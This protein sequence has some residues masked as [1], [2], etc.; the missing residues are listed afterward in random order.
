MGVLDEQTAAPV[1]IKA[2]GA[3]TRSSR[4]FRLGLLADAGGAHEDKCPGWLATTALMCLA[5]RL[6]RVF[7]V[8]PVVDG[9]NQ[10]T[11]V[12]RL[13]APL[14]RA[15]SRGQASNLGPLRVQALVPCIKLPAEK[16]APARQTNSSEPLSRRLI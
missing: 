12:R 13:D 1:K 9:P 10:M 8:A 15:R 11:L 5:P 16:L 7:N 14:G 2:L 4:D 6:A 3:A